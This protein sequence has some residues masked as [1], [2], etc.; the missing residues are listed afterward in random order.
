MNGGK[1]GGLDFKL[2]NDGEGLWLYNA[3]GQLIDSVMFG[4]QVEG[5][6]IGRA[7]REAN[8]TLT[9]PTFGRKTKPCHLAKRRMFGSPAGQPTRRTVKAIG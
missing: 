7:G 6:S 1:N 8:W 4:R 3:E 2:D 5:L 9:H